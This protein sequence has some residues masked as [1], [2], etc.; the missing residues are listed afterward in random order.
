MKKPEIW[1][2]GTFVDW[3]RASVHVLSHS[4]QRGSTVF[5]SLS[6]E[7]TP[8]GPAIFRLDA[9][10]DRFLQS[11]QLTQMSIPFSG[12]ELMEATKETVRRSGLGRCCIRPLSFYVGEELEV[13][14][15]GSTVQVIIAVA[16]PIEVP[17]RFRAKV[18][19]VRKL[20]PDTVPVAAKVAGNYLS[21][22][23]A[24][25]E[26][27]DQG[28]DEAILLDWAGNLAEG[29]T[30]SLF[31]VKDGTIKTAP[32]STVLAGI[33]RDSVIGIARDMGYH[34]D[35][36]T[37]ISGAELYDADEV[38][39]TGT[40][41]GVVSV[42]QIDDRPVEAGSPGGI[43]KALREAYSDAAHGKVAKYIHWLTYV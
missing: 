26:A 11:G 40:G 29:P 12:A 6:C 16:P 36:E 22:M 31:I 23:L 14:P 24:K 27:L 4:L 30:E 18:S 9:H 2:N 21:A 5:E 35:D 3:E 43:T 7:E 19:S 33:T 13:V 10:V 42:I 34:V 39:V 28:F 1:I 38:F 41:A 37:V 32:L 25:R 8:K 15:K 17:D 20:H